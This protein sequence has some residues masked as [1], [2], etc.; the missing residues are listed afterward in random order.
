MTATNQIDLFFRYTVKDQARY[1][2]YLDQVF[3]L[4]QNE[5]YVLEYHID[6]EANG[7]MLQHERYE[8]EAAIGKHTDNTA[9]AQ[10]AFAEST[11]INDFRAVGPLS[12]EFRNLIGGMGLPAAFFDRFRSVDR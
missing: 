4:T 6:R 12:D 5:T 10:A 7:T 11:E 8:N 2:D 3:P 9:A 1:Q